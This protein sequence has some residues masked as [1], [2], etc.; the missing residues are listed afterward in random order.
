NC[1][2]ESLR[3]EDE[4]LMSKVEGV[5]L[6]NKPKYFN[7]IPLIINIDQ[8]AVKKVE[9]LDLQHTGSDVNTKI[10]NLTGLENFYELYSLFLQ[11]NDIKTIDQL[12]YATDMQTLLLANNPNLSDNNSSIIKMPGLINLDL[13]NTGMTNIDNINKALDENNKTKM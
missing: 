7:K 13:S 9:V 3:F 4:I 11:D 6:S 5:L 10:K 8:D 12:Q 2:I 1:Y